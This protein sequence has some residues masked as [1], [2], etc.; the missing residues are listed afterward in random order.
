MSTRAEQIR[1]AAHRVARAA[2][3]TETGAAAMQRPRSMLGRVGVA[4][5]SAKLAVQVARIGT[6][7]LR[8]HPFAGTAILAIG[9]V[10][11]LASRNER[12]PRTPY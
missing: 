4:I 8:R 3:T 2:S 10:A 7:F 6:A 11:Y 9:V 12:G 1:R 5:S